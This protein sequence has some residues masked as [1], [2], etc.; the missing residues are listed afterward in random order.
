MYMT[1]SSMLTFRPPESSLIRLFQLYHRIHPCRIALQS[2]NRFRTQ[3]IAPRVAGQSHQHSWA[4]VRHCLFRL[5]GL[6]QQH[7]T[8]VDVDGTEALGFGDCDEARFG[9]VMRRTD[10]TTVHGLL[11]FRNVVKPR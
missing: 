1:L 2:R 10:L 4:R 7:A 5:P 6:C 8:L 3:D 9:L 11:G